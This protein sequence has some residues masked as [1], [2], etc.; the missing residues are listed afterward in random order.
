[1]LEKFCAAYCPADILLKVWSRGVLV[2]NDSRRGIFRALLLKPLTFLS[3]HKT[4]HTRQTPTSPV[5]AT[6]QQSWPLI[7][8]FHAL[9]MPP[10]PSYSA[11]ASLV[12]TV[13]PQSHRH[14]LSDRPPRHGR[15]AGSF[16][17]QG[18]LAVGAPVV[19]RAQCP[20]RRNRRRQRRRQDGPPHNLR[21]LDEPHAARVGQ[22]V[23]GQCRPSRGGNGCSG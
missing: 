13:S 12:L 21:S 11:E 17:R 9:C 4:P 22:C 16:S 5:T 7:L 6:Q 19:C 14:P 20:R 15:P 23:P 3:Q 10:F 2:A 1:M 8:T 18:A